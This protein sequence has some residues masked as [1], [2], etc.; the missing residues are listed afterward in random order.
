MGETPQSRESGRSG[1]SG[2]RG[3]GAAALLPPG[4]VVL[5]NLPRTTPQPSGVLQFSDCFLYQRRQ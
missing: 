3:A 2:V 5:G 1:E 4:K